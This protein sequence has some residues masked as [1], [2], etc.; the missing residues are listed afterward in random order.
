LEYSNIL[1]EQGYV[2]EARQAVNEAITVNSNDI[3]Y[4]SIANTLKQRIDRYE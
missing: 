4:V 1:L 2:N 3:G